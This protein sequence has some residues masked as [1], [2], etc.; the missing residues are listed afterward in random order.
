MST[1][2]KQ[3]WMTRLT[4]MQSRTIEYGELTVNI[5]EGALGDGL[6]ARVWVVAHTL[7]RFIALVHCCV[8]NR[9]VF[10]PRTAA[11]SCR[12]PTAS[13]EQSSAIVLSVSSVPDYVVPTHLFLPVR[14]LALDATCIRARP[15]H[16]CCLTVCFCPKTDMRALTASLHAYRE[17]LAHPSIVAGKTVLEIGSGCGLCGIVAAKL[18]A[19]QVRQM[20]QLCDSAFQRCLC[21]EMKSR[22]VIPASIT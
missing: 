9:R 21:F 15:C 14:K 7:C 11:V 19:Q 13:H 4:D 2:C 10:G 20:V 6:G 16:E 17:L 8:A 1:I 18:G 5:Q 22:H 12:L 3:I